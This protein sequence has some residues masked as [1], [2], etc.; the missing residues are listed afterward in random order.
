MH[1][2]A[3]LIAEGEQFGVL[4]T[5]RAAV[6]HSHCGRGRRRWNQVLRAQFKCPNG[7]RDLSSLKYGLENNLKLS[8]KFTFSLI[9]VHP[10]PIT[11]PPDQRGNN[12]C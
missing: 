3:D 11:F 9:S 6:R 1:F 2:P 10:K 8:D 7:I 5:Q 4:A 12:L